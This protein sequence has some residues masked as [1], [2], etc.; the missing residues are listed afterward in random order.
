MA[1][2]QSQTYANTGDGYYL[3]NGGVP[4]VPGDQTVQGPLEIKGTSVGLPA[5]YNRFAQSETTGLSI[6]E[7]KTAGNVL[8]SDIKL[9]TDI[10]PPAV[11]ISTYRPLGQEATLTVTSDDSK[12]VVKVNAEAG[13]VVGDKSGSGI[14][15]QLYHEP[16]ENRNVIRNYLYG[17]GA[18][19]SL[20]GNTGDIRIA[21]SGTFNNIIIPTTTDKI[22][23]SDNGAPSNTNLVGN[24]GIQITA[25]SGGIYG[26]R[27]GTFGGTGMTL[28][29]KTNIT[30]RT[31]YGGSPLTNLTCNTDGSVTI[32]T[33]NT[34]TGN[35]TTL[36]TTT[37]NITT[38]NTTTGN[39]TT[40]NSTTINNTGLTTTGTLT[41]NTSASIPAIT[42]LASVNSIPIT[43]FVTPTGCVIPFTGLSANIPNG[44][45]LCN[46]QFVS[47]TTYSTL[48]ALIA[49]RY[50]WSN[51]APG[52]QFAVPDLRLKAPF[53]ASDPTSYDNYQFIV[54]AT[55]FAS[56]PG[57]N[58]TP[59]NPA[60]GSPYPATQC[61]YVTSVP[62]GYAIFPNMNF[63]AGSSERLIIGV[64]NSTSASGATGIVL[65]LESPL[66]SFGPINCTIIVNP[67]SPFV[68]SRQGVMG[69]TM[70]Q[71]QTIQANNEVGIHTHGTV[72]T[73]STNNASAASGRS[74]P[75]FSQPVNQ[76]N[77]TYT[78]NGVVYTLP[79]SMNNMP[80]AVFMNYLIKY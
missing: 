50:D 1:S 5:Y 34:T 67:S 64:I 31:N 4:L 10:T 76:Y 19:I 54:T 38:I 46:G 63:F 79:Y 71:N 23:I 68:N 75:N 58:V 9:T 53:G 30:L 52:G 44:Y 43:D 39:I 35:I 20:G 36:N 69:Q 47:Q 62:A 45:L 49:N 11:Q 3:R 66:G 80:S 37:G 61:A 6:S 57:T 74:E 48:Y 41:V 56:L 2:L 12:G 8:L 72:A 13:L 15:L 7:N 29:S 28:D 60:T 22:I 21:N 65:V 18:E 40:V 77:G 42:N 25:G 16:G 24:S 73:S 32:T 26:G 51:S 78:V 27:V 14:S 59:T 17:G 55:S 70:F 33:L